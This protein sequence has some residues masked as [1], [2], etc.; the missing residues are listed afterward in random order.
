MSRQHLG[1]A[2]VGLG[3]AGRVPVPIARRRHRVHRVE[4][5]AG[6]HQRGDEQSPVG[7]DADHHLD[8]IF[9]MCADQLVEPGDAIHPFGQP[10]LG[11]P[12]A[13]LV[14]HVHV[15]MGLGPIHSYKDHPVASRLSD[16]N[17]R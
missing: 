3:A 4:L 8:G 6:R 5:V 2:G 9:D 16:Q 10:G 15:V 7:L 13:F 11:Q 1:V 12:A 14:G 17:L